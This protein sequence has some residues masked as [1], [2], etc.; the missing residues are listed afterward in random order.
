ML[1]N[2]LGDV[3]IVQESC[4][5][6]I[7]K[8]SKFYALILKFITLNLI[9]FVADE[10]CMFETN[11]LCFLRGREKLARIPLLWR[12]TPSPNQTRV[13]LCDAHTPL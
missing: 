1:F 7:V 2:P 6:I 8:D 10:G 9:T 12:H 5:S 3:N 4:F 11:F 13:F